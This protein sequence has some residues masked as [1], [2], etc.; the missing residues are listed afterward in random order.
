ML[1]ITKTK[2]MKSSIKKKLVSSLVKLD[3]KYPQIA[4]GGCG[5]FA[6]VLATELSKSGID[7]SLHIAHGSLMSK[8]D[9]WIAENDSDGSIDLSGLYNFSWNHVYVKVDGELIDSSGVYV[10]TFCNPRFD[11][12]DL[13]TPIS[14]NMLTQLINSTEIDWNQTFERSNVEALTSDIASMVNNNF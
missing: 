7:F 3:K 5:I 10:N 4:N 1:L 13:S 8:V 14:S 9:L 11:D 2:I 12:L 6:S